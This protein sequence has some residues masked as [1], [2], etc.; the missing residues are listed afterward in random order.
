[1]TLQALMESLIVYFQKSIKKMIEIQN[2]VSMHLTAIL[3]TVI[4]SAQS[5]VSMSPASTVSMITPFPFT[6]LAHSLLVSAAL[7]VDHQALSTFQP[8]AVSSMKSI[9][10]HPLWIYPG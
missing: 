9:F 3:T 10:G 6:V 8:A 5:T 1:M 2:T 7:T 4:T